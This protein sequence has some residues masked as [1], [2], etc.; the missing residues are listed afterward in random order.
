MARETMK[1]RHDRYQRVCIELAKEVDR[2]RNLLSYVLDTYAKDFQEN[3]MRSEVEP[4][5]WAQWR[6][7]VKP[8]RCELQSSSNN[9]RTFDAPTKEPR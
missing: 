9:G 6:C 1:E 2:L 5:R 7:G 8:S 4:S 3:V